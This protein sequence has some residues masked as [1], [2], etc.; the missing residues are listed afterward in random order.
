VGFVKLIDIILNRERFDFCGGRMRKNNGFTLIEL[1]VTIAVLAIVASFA[2]PSFKSMIENQKLTKSTN[3][4]VQEIKAARIKA[5]LD[6]KEITLKLNSS[7][8]DAGYILNWKPEGEVSLKIASDNEL[9]FNGNGVLT[10]AFSV[11]ELCKV[12]VFTPAKPTNSKKI[13]LTK[14]GQVE[15]IEDGSCP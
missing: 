2:V 6:K 14:F 13:T 5:I 12:S 15:K 4:L 3:S 8:A 11:I 9:K 7:A 1:M 10:S